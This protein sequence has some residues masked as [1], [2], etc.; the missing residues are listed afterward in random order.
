MDLLRFADDSALTPISE[1]RQAAKRRA[2]KSGEKLSSAL[3]AIAKDIS[4]PRWDALIEASWVLHC[5]ATDENPDTHYH[6]LNGIRAGRHVSI[7]LPIQTHSALEPF[8]ISLA[9]HNWTEA[10]V[11]QQVLIVGNTAQEGRLLTLHEHDVASLKVANTLQAYVRAITPIILAAADSDIPKMV[12]KLRSDQSLFDASSKEPPAP[13]DT[14]RIIAEIPGERSYYE[15]LLGIAESQASL[16]LRLR[17]EETPGLGAFRFQKDGSLIARRAKFKSSE[18]AREAITRAVHVISFLSWTGLEYPRGREDEQAKQDA[19]AISQGN[20]YDHYHVLRETSSGATVVLNQPYR[21]HR[22]INTSGL[23]NLLRPGSVTAEAP[24]FAGLLGVSRTLFHSLER[25]GADLESITTGAIFAFLTAKHADIK[26]TE[27][28]VRGPKKKGSGN[29]LSSD[30]YFSLVSDLHFDLSDI[31][32]AETQ[33]LNHE[34][35]SVDQLR[36]PYWRNKMK[37]FEGK[38]LLSWELQDQYEGGGITLGDVF[39]KL[40]A[41][42]LDCDIWGFL[43]LFDFSETTNAECYRRGAIAGEIYLGR[44]YFTRETG[45]FWSLVETRPYMRSLNSLYRSLVKMKRP[46][47]A[48]AIGVRMLELSPNDNMGISRSIKDVE[49]AIR[50]ADLSSNLAELFKDQDQSTAAN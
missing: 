46:A 4:Y 24:A 28:S 27:Q 8:D 34:L 36:T 3:D 37:A 25:Q 9:V 2:K 15:V 12:G 21:G 10:N 23:L 49:A 18:S 19:Y 26:M 6:L 7:A 20:L 13:H 44:K 41:C 33:L 5:A 43:H 29:V 31:P 38:E 45:S 1:L 47:D 48:L 16:H 39:E 40:R 42:P 14:V 32:V 17:A 30:E 22:S 35:P 11:F 50:D